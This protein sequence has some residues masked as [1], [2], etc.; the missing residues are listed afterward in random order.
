M[1]YR[2]LVV[3]DSP[4]M[5]GFI[6]RVLDLSG[7]EVS[8]VLEA[9]NG[10]DALAILEDRPVDIVLTD[11]NMPRMNG[12]ELIRQLGE[13]EDLRDIPVLVISGDSSEARVN[14]MLEIGA[15]GC[16]AKPFSPERL[17]AELDRVM[18]VWS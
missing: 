11:I 7:F 13:D 17:R 8:E 16:L 6:K 15:R 1:A 4:A 2:V 9:G 10:L 3:D 18:G 12:E 5:R 14:R